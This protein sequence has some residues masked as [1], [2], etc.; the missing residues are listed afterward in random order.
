MRRRSRAP[1][2]FKFAMGY[3]LKQAIHFN[4]LSVEEAAP[5]LKVKKSALYNFINGKE[6]PRSDVLYRAFKAWPDMQFIYQ[7]L[8]LKAE[9]KPAKHKS[10][11]QGSLFEDIKEKDLDISILDQSP[12]S[13][14][15]SVKIRVSRAGAA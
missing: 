1:K 3:T 12:R 15:L 10:E 4:G 6:T 13:V 7:G 11:A 5:L 9:I 8:A 2:G 14:E